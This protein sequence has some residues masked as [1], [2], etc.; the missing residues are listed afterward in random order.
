M[1]SKYQDWKLSK[2]QTKILNSCYMYILTQSKWAQFSGVFIS[3]HSRLNMEA[4]CCREQMAAD[5]ED[6]PKPLIVV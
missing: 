2:G 3:A 5:R 1:V 6:P 4:K